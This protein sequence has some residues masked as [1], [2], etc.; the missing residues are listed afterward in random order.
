MGQSVLLGPA[1]RKICL[2]L[3]IYLLQEN[4]NCKQC[5]RP[6]PLITRSESESL[7]QSARYMLAGS[8][9]HVPPQKKMFSLIK[10]NQNCKQCCRPGP[11]ITRS[12]SDHLK[13]SGSSSS[14]SVSVHTGRKYVLVPCTA[15]KKKGFRKI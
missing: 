12:E 7:K 2:K 3:Y 4:R 8:M 10:E 6:G 11:L 14:S 1:Y 15:A 5:C 9:Y 13:Q